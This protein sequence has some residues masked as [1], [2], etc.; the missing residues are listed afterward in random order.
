MLQGQ[1]RIILSP[2]MTVGCCVP[3]PPHTHTPEPLF[4]PGWQTIPGPTWYF[5]HTANVGGVYFYTVSALPAD[6]QLQATLVPKLHVSGCRHLNPS[7]LPLLV[8]AWGKAVMLCD[9]GSSSSLSPPHTLTSGVHLPDTKWTL[10]CFQLRSLVT[11]PFTREWAGTHLCLS[12]FG[13]C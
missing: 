4:L 3:V 9:C 8:N 12:W 5:T 1:T 10:A 6:H 11:E 7:F 2:W 13:K